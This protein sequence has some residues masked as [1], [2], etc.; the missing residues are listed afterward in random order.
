M[1]ENAS[2]VGCHPDIATEWTRSLHRSSWRDPVFQKAYAVEPVAFCRG[3]HAPESDAAQEPEL[4]AQAVGIGCVSCHVDA[5]GIHAARANPSAQHA[6]VVDA[7]LATP[8]LCARCHE[9]DFPADSHQLHPQAMQD[10]VAEHA[11]GDRASTPCQGCHMPV[12]DGPDGRHR[13]HSFQ[14]IEDPALLRAAVHI[15]AQQLDDGVRLTLAAAKI[16]HAFPTGDM[17]RRL[18][19]RAKRVDSRGKTIATATP[20]VLERRFEDRPRDPLAEE[21]DMMRVE[22]EDTRV[23]PPGRGSR[24]VTLALPHAEG[25]VVWSVVYQRMSTPMAAAF[26]VS[27][28]L[29]EVLLAEGTLPPAR[30]YAHGDPR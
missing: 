16:G 23:P 5:A 29:D 27:Q 7:T 19:V 2:C 9:F 25:R 17:F 11:S 18:E 28:V 6:V 24:I 8:K 10:T 26:G 22:A 21:L 4:R 30:L 1:A 13:S 20:V 14:V 3:C 15:E 12:V